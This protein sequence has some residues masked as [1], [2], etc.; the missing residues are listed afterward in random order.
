M[1][2]GID[3]SIDDHV[4]Q[5]TIDRQERLNSL[6]QH[7]QDELERVW[8]AI[9]CDRSVRLVVLTGAGDR[10]FCAG[11]DM[12]SD[13][14]KVDLD[15]WLD[16]RPNGFGHL[17]LRTTLDVPVIGRINGYALGGG[18]ELVIGCDVAVAVDD[19][20]FGFVE[21]RLGRLPLD[22]GIVSLTRQL[23]SK[24]AM[25]IL[26]T[27]RRFTASEALRFG[28]VNQVVTRDEL[29]ATVDRWVEACLACAPL[30]LRAIK[31]I[32]K[33]TPHL[34]AAEARSMRLPALVEVLQSRDA[35][36]GLRAFREK[37][38]PEWSGA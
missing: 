29:N 22:G 25:E 7:A 10:A 32:V 15:Y 12:K 19:A 5:V 34:S 1:S 35:E 16:P 38:P 2:N 18:L 31:Q 14:G 27:G 30:S 33:R 11:D 8:Q 6:D 37:R 28:L 23:P 17:P 3:F 13:L 24:F 4:A 9:E 26:L 20:E 36:E 21:P